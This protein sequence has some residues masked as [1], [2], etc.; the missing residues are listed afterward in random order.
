ML[1]KY[2]LEINLKTTFFLESDIEEKAPCQ[3]KILCQ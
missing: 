1:G 3:I 2:Y